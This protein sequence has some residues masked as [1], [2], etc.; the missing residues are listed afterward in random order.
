MDWISEK[1]VTKP[2]LQRKT[3][4]VMKIIILNAYTGIV[5]G[6]TVKLLLT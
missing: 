4:T 6:C 3:V 5:S 1:S 2:L